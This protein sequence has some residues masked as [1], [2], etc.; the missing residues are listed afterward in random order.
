MPRFRIASTTLEMVADGIDYPLDELKRFW[1]D[2]EALQVTLRLSQPAG[3]YL[4]LAAAVDEELTTGQ[5]LLARYTALT[6]CVTNNPP[7]CLFIAACTAPSGSRASIIAGD[8]KNSYARVHTDC[9][10]LRF[11]RW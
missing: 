11:R 1:P 10:L 5:K 4:A 8:H 2:K 9:K 3:G 7:G 6:E